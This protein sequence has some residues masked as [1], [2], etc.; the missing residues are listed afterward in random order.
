MHRK[1]RASHAQGLV[2]YALI[3]ALVALLV[4]GVAGL[5][6]WVLQGGLGHV[7]GALLG[8]RNQASSSGHLTILKVE[9]EVGNKIVVDLSTTYPAAE[10]TLRSNAADW[11]WDGVPGSN[12]H[13]ESGLAPDYSCPL[14]VVVQHQ[15]SGNIA[16]SG[17][18]LV[19]FP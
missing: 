6:G 4:I 16:A 15:K 18:A 2:E 12:S 5:L 11:Y 10:L 7:V 14:S 19:D 9:C 1:K 17:V 13:I 8:P 3:I